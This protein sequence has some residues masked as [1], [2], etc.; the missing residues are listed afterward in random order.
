MKQKIINSF[1][2]FIFL[3]I[4][5]SLFKLQVI[6]QRIYKYLSSKNSIRLLPQFGARGKILDRNGSV[7]IGN[8]LSYDVLVL[9]QEE[10]QINRTIYNVSRILNI[11]SDR[12]KDKFK[13]DYIAP[14]IPV[15]IAQNIDFKQ[16]IALEEARLESPGIIIQPHPL[17][18][19]P[20]GSLASHVIGYLGEIDRWRLTKLADYGYKTKDIVG[21]GGIE[22]KYDYYLRQEEG[23]LSVEVDHQGKFI[24]TLG[25]RPPKNGKDIQLTLDLNIQEI[26]ENNLRGHIGSVI[27]MAPDTGEIIAMASYPDFNPEVFIKDSPSRGG[28]FNDP[29]APLLNRAISGVYPPGSVFKSVVAAAGLETGKI[30]LSS[31][32]LCTGSIY[33]GNQEFS[34]WDTHGQQGLLQALAHSCN[35]FFYKTGLLLG[36]EQIHYYA[37]KFGLGRTC[38]IDLPY[39]SSGIV[40]SPLWKRLHRFKGWYAGDTVNF[41]IGQGDLLVTPLQMTRMM[42]VFANSGMLVTPYIVKAI[43]GEDISI[44][45]KKAQRLPLKDSTVDYIRSGLRRVVSEPTGTAR[46]LSGLKVDVAGKTGTAQVSRGQPHAWFVGFFPFKNPKFVI[47]VFLEHG[48][49]AAASCS[50]ARQIIEEIC[51]R[52]LI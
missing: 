15:V 39:E 34:C 5:L 46:V 6:Q 31:T 8:Y 17:R 47:C 3:F 24:R 32:F 19:Y 44:Y 10:A 22:E 50:L 37:V 30:N 43:D 18:D 14:S 45:Q 26:A 20:Y 51:K 38:G 33:I 13:S 9:P 28:L 36:A 23:A 41:A 42:A 4:G 2:L 11:T 25:Y 35:I 16:A 21:F 40:P 12:L 27:L 49:S 1:I 29:K 48:G 7:I 52:G